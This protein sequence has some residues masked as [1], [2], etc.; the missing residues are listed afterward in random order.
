L[1]AAAAGP[2]SVIY[3][4]YLNG[5][6]STKLQPQMWCLVISA[7]SLVLGLATYGYNVCRCAML[8]LGGP[9]LLLLVVVETG[10]AL[11]ALPLAASQSQVD[12]MSS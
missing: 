1:P 6:L 11:P 7:L 12:M 10:H 3:D 8:L 4:I 9:A 2:L 5:T